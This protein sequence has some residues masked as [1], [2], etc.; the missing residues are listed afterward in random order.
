MKKSI[1]VSVV[2]PAFNE[3][4]NIR[5]AVDTVQKA[6]HGHVSDYEII[7]IDDGSLDDTGAIAQGLHKKDPR[8]RVYHNIPNRGF[9]YSI[10]RGIGAAKKSYV[11]LFPSD[12]EISGQ[13]LSDMVRAVRQTDFVTAYNK[14]SH[15]R[16][17][18]RRFLSW[19]FVALFNALFGFHQR[20][21]TGPFIGKTKDIQ[22]LKL[23]SDGNALIAELKI[24]ML[25]RGI[26]HKE[27][28]F[29]YQPRAHGTSV[30][31]SQKS[32]KQT[33]YTFWILMRELL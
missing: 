32:I 3:A 24:R 30:A 11:T 13:S 31:L 1:D 18:H 5:S 2:M 15:D 12:N 14:N 16:P 4:E 25:M 17:L 20:Y 6:L 22:S 7:I 28:P 10:K 21:Y 26:S 8:I 33:L 27:I 29:T 9:G 23:K 19:L